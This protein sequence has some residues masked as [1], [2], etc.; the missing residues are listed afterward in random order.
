MTLFTL[1][2]AQFEKQDYDDAVETY[3]KALKVDRWNK[4][5]ATR[6]RF[7]RASAHFKLGNTKEVIEDCSVA[8]ESDMCDHKPLVLLG[9][10]YDRLGDHQNACA[11]YE[12]ALTL[13]KSRELQ[14][15]FAKAEKEAKA[16]RDHTTLG[17]EADATG[18]QISQ[19]FQQHMQQYMRDVMSRIYQVEMIQRVYKFSRVKIAYDRMLKK[20]KKDKN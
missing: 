5:F 6:I 10:L 20:M 2:K 13:H 9:N 7:L 4:T 3:N 14:K 16:T 17:V 1:A 15:L 18:Q 8:F 11:V 19:A 12:K